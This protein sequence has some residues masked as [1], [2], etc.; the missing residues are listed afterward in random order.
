M[1]PW[2]NDEE[3][4][5][6]MITNIVLN[7]MG[8]S[9]NGFEISKCTA[10]LIWEFKIT[11]IIRKTWES[12]QNRRCL[13]AGNFCLLILNC[14]IGPMSMNG[15]C[16]FI[17]YILIWQMWPRLLINFSNVI[18]RNI[19]AVLMCI[20]PLRCLVLMCIRPLQCMLSPKLTGTCVVH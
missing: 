13:H 11:L 6:I 3:N 1:H 4:V 12:W 16:I 9:L 7:L 17:S 10:Y 5:N 18:L 2:L 20:K 8:F 19:I 14:L 15:I